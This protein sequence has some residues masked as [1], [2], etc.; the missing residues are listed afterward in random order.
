MLFKQKVICRCTIIV[1]VSLNTFFSELIFKS[2]LDCLFKNFII[3]WNSM[4][5]ND[6][7][8]GK[9]NCRRREMPP[10]VFSDLINGESFSRVSVQYVCQHIL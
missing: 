2:K 3:N 10:S 9:V 7:S 5:P 4:I 6:D 1:P 8:V